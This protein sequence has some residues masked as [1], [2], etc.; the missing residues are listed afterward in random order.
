MPIGFGALAGLSAAQSGLNWWTRN[1]QN[2]FN[3]G[4]QQNQQ[5]WNLDQWNREKNWGM[6]QWGMQNQYNSPQAQMQRLKDAGLNPHLIY[7]KG[8]S[9]PN[10]AD[11]PH[12]PDVKGYTRAEAANSVRGMDAFRDMVSFR[13]TAAQT[14]NVKQSTALS[15]Q[16]E[17]LKAVQTANAA[18]QGDHSK[19]NLHIAKELEQ[20]SIQAAQTNL[21]KLQHQT[22]K[23]EAETKFAI[24]SAPIRIQKL[25]EEANN[26][27]LNGDLTRLKILESAWERELNKANLTK[28]DSAWLRFGKL[29]FDALK[30]KYPRKK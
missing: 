26:A 25:L 5:Q 16:E 3:L 14:D 21:E 7:G 6:T 15:Q 13:H 17:L 20:T 4:Q 23:A 12:T 10:T 27:R 1:Q 29:T 9:A 22:N 8:S 18:I 28:S 19:L 24:K 11:Q 30:E 2:K